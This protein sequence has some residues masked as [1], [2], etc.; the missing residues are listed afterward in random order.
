MA[1]KTIKTLKSNLGASS[2]EWVYPLVGKITICEH[3]N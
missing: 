1:E 2:D 3:N